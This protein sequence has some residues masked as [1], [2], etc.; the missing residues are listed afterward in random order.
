MANPGA[1]TSVDPGSILTRYERGERIPDIAEDHGVTEQAIYRLLLL[2]AGEAWK[3]YQAAS[4][5]RRLEN[6]TEQLET[7]RA[8]LELSR[9]RERVRAA[10]WELERLCR[11]IYGQ[12]QA[13]GS[14]SPVQININLRSGGTTNAVQHEVI[15]QP[16][17]R[18]Q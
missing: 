8:A 12:D 9:A 5:L 6:A 3:D 13:V 14:S 1:L 18:D 16:L 4:A 11:R 17:D 2:K 15:E 7:A 10:Q